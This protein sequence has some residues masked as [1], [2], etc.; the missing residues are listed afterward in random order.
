MAM[1]EQRKR[2]SPLTAFF[3]GLFGV[4]GTSI[5]CITTL[6]LYGMNIVERKADG[7]LNLAG[8]AVADLPAI[9]DALPP[10]LKGLIGRRDPQY[11][12]HIDVAVTFID[13]PYGHGTVPSLTI[14]NN[15][16]ETVCMLA[17][18]VAA[19]NA[20]GVPLRDWTEVVVTPIGG[21][22]ESRHSS[23]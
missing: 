9:I 15:G 14:K 6:G 4:G 18:R 16:D 20:A 19:L 11:R 17:V 7:I 8:T 12:K 21:D 3:I 10:S 13:S 23:T 22:D 1:I 2:M 5:V